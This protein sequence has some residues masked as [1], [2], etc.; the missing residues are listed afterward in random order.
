MFAL[1]SST[2]L[3]LGLLA[4]GAAEAQTVADVAAFGAVPDDG[5]DD[6][7]AFLAA[8]KEVARTGARQLVFHAG[9]YDLEAG[10]NPE[11]A[12][13]LFALSNLN[14][15]TIDGGGAE[16]MVK[17]ATSLFSFVNCRDITLRNFSVDCARAPFS[18]GEV[19]AAEPRW[20]DV[21]VADEFPVA[22]G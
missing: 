13:L 18:V 4:V 19:V 17:G 8:L 20:F 10:R 1:T 2:A 6:T 11:N 12:Q 9:R 5:Q 14:G 21:R 7:D 16:L 15:L 22:G 3:V